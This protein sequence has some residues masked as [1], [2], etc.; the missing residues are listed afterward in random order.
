MQDSKKTVKTRISDFMKDEWSDYERV[1]N[2]QMHW[3]EVMIEPVDTTYPRNK[4][5]KIVE[6]ISTLPSEKKFISNFLPL[7]RTRQKSFLPLR[8]TRQKI[9]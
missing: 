9:Y 4:L 2:L 8:R 3:G 5:D 6:V 1:N 7:R